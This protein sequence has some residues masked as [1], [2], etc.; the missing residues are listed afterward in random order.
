MATTVP[1][2]KTCPECR[3]EYA[4]DVVSCPQDKSLLMGA[5][6]DPLVGTKLGKYEILSILGRGAVGNVYKGRQD[7]I[8]RI[9]ALKVLQSRHLSDA[10]SLK[11]F[12]REGKATCRLYHPHII[13][14][15]DFNVQEETGQ[16]YIVMD[17]LKGVSLSE[18]IRTEERVKVAR[19]INIFLQCCEAL[20]HAHDQGIIHR[21]FKPSNIVLIDFDGDR[22]FVKVLDFG[23]AH[24]INDG[25][26]TTM[27][28][29]TGSG[30]VCGSPLYMS[31]EQC[32]GTEL[33][34]RSD[35]Y[36]MGV[37]MYET[38]I[39]K[40]PFTGKTVME[41]MRLHS[42]EPVPK[43]STVRP[44]LYIPQQLESIVRR[45]LAK[46]PADRHQSMK[47][48]AAELNAIAP[49]VKRSSILPAY[50][51]KNFH[52]IQ[53]YE[54]TF[55]SLIKL[56]KSSGGATGFMLTQLVKALKAIK[57]AVKRN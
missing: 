48:L 33:D 4:G 18:V 31:P 38:I 45:A 12:Q 25:S 47:E 54:Q 51:G 56:A 1:D 22:D 21:D 23:I 32:R 39:G 46:H 53:P 11:R 20:D 19:A 49:D 3:R 27:Q 7:E 13:T 9:V 2:K 34:F 50:Q 15:Y 43:F 28:R 30:D 57:R 17:Y 5:I 41:T 36:A 26:R 37:V 8:D 55:G 40:L 29:L 10:L 42:E 44:D 24:L 35:I 52:K 14:V 6:S 16:P